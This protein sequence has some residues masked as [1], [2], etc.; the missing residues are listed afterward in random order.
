MEKTTKLFV[1]LHLFRTSSWGLLPSGTRE[2]EVE[3]E[4]KGHE[5]ALSEGL[6]YGYSL[7]IMDCIEHDGKI[8]ESKE[9]KNYKTV[10]FGK[11]YTRKEIKRMKDCKWLAKAMKADREEKAVKTRVYDTWISWIEDAEYVSE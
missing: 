7:G 3:S 5:I 11:V 9:I 1:T 6:C 8:Y 4:E 2:L 10:I